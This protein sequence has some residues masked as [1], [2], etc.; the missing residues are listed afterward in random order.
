MH[1]VVPRVQGFMSSTEDISEIGMKLPTLLRLPPG[2][3]LELDVY[4]S[5]SARPVTI[6]GEVVWQLPNKDAKFPVCIGIQF[7]Q[8]NTVEYRKVVEHIRKKI[9]IERIK[10]EQEKKNV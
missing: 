1:R 2:V 6:R 10:A 4:L 3:L 8:Q 9:A 5:D 7:T